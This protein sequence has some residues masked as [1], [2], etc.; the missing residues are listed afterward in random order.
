MVLQ[1]VQFLQ[2]I[3]PDLLFLANV[4][5]LVVI[6][7]DLEHFDHNVV[8]LGGIRSQ[9]LI[10]D[11]V[12]HVQL[13]FLP[14]VEFIHQLFDVQVLGDAVE[15]HL[16]AFVVL[17]ELLVEE[18]AGLSLL[19]LQADHEVLFIGLVALLR[20][21]F[22]HGEDFFLLLE[23]AA[24]PE[25]HLH[26]LNVLLRLL[27]V[28]RLQAVLP[29]GVLDHLLLHIQ[30][31]LDV[32]QL[33]LVRI[34]QRLYQHLVVAVE[35]IVNQPHRLHSLNTHHHLEVLGEL[36]LELVV[37][38]LVAVLERAEVVPDPEE[39]PHLHHL[40]LVDAL[41]LLGMAEDEVQTL[42]VVLAP[43]IDENL[44]QVQRGLRG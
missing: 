44:H 40:R 1:R 35:L 39:D 29:D 31:R 14:L 28:R 6:L 32:L 33:L 25:V 8:D 36:A 2:H 43:L 20:L 24:E 11:G 15:V 7:A 26:E 34:E 27:R 37:E 23:L 4:D 17:A 42:L 10:L 3:I 41:S 13:P 30:H 21:F 12:L 9:L 16:D 22:D 5:L 38:L 18:P 19:E